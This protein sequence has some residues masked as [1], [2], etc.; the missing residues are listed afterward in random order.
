[1]SFG[2]AQV[3]E[4]SKGEMQEVAEGEGATRDYWST[5]LAQVEAQAAAADSAEKTGRGAKRRAT[6]KPQVGV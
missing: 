4:R 3:W 6:K 5:L 2:F 1:M